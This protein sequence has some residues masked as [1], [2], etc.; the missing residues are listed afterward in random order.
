[1]KRLLIAATALT[2]LVQPVSAQPYGRHW[3]H[4]WGHPVAPYGAP[5]AFWGGAILGGL[6]GSVLRPE[7]PPVIVEAPI[8]EVVPGSPAWNAYCL[9]RYASFDP[10]SGTYLGYDNLR[11]PCR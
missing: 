4:G 6:I 7:P 5:G 2:L 10:A 3:G 1:M 8:P 9:N 11:H